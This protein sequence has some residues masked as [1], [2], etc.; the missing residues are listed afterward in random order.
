[1]SNEG[2]LMSYNFLR[3]AQSITN[4]YLCMHDTLDAYVSDFGTNGDVDGWDVYYNTY[5][6]GCWGGNLFGTA[7]DRDP[8]IGRTT[9][10]LS[11]EA[12]HFYYIKIMMKLTNNNTNKIVGGLTKGKIRWLTTTDTLWDSNKEIE[13]DITADDQW[14]LYTINV[15]PSSRWVG[16][17]NNLRIYPFTD[18]WS[19]DQFTIR[20]IKISSL[21]TFHCTNSSCSYYAEYEHECPGAG[22][23]GSCEAGT[24]REYYTLSSGINDQLIINIDGYGDE[25]FN[26]GSYE[27]IDGKE[28]AKVLGN[29][30]S[31]LNIGGYAYVTVEHTFFNRLKITS[32]T[33]GDESSVIVRSCTA[34]EELGFYSS[35]VDISSRSSGEDPATGF[36]Y[37]SSRLLTAYEINKL[38]DGDT[39]SFAYI[40]NPD[41]KSVEGGRNDY[42]QVGIGEGELDFHGNKTYVIIPNRGKT[43]ID[44]SHPFNNNGKITA[45][46]VYGKLYPNASIKIC[47]PHADGSFTVVH[48]LDVPQ[49]NPSKMYTKLHVNFRID[50]DI[51][52][53]KGDYIGVYD[54][55]LYVGKNLGDVP[56]ATYS[57]YNGEASGNFNVSEQYS[58]GVAGLA[59]YGRGDRAQT[60]TILDIDLGDRT[61][62]EEI[63]VYGREEKAY[64]DFNVMACL[65]MDWDVDT[66][67]ETHK[68][69]GFNALTG[70]GFTETHD[71]IAIGEE[72]LS[73]MIITPDNGHAGDSL[74]SESGIHSYFY[75]TGDA[76]WLNNFDCDGKHEFCWPRTASDTVS[77]NYDPVAFTAYFPYDYETKI[78]RSIIYFKEKNNFR[79]FTLSYYMGPYSDDGNADLK[80]FMRI[81]SYNSV[82]LD[83][84][85][86]SSDTSTV[87]PYLYS[88]PT[89]AR[90]TQINKDAY[91][92]SLF[93]D[94]TILEHEFDEIE[95]K[96]FRIYCNE[97]YSTKITEIELYSKLATDPSLSDNL[98]I[99]FSDYGNVWRSVS[100]SS[101]GNNKVSAFVGGSPRYFKIEIDSATQFEINELEVNVGDQ[102]VM[103]NCDDEVLL[104]EAKG[105]GAS[106]STSITFE[107]VYDKP[108]DLS[109]DIPRDL[110]A[111][112][113]GLLFSSPL[114]SESSIE[115]PEIGPKAILYEREDYPITNY[116]G[117]CAIN[118]ECYGLK[119]L[120]DDKDAYYTSRGVW[121]SFGTL[122]SGISLNYCNTD[123]RI[124]NK[125]IIDID[126]V[127]SSLYWKIA[128]DITPLFQSIAID[129]VKVYKGGSSLDIDRVYLEESDDTSSQTG[130]ITSDGMELNIDND[131]SVFGF[132]LADGDDT[133]DR[134]IIYH[135]DPEGL[136][137]A[138]LGDISGSSFVDSGPSGYN[139]SIYGNPTAYDSTEVEGKLVYFDGNDDITLMS[140]SEASTFESRFSVSFFFKSTTNGGD[141]GARVLTRDRSDYFAIL[142]NQ[143][144]G[145]PQTLEFADNAGYHYFNVVQ[146]DTLHHVVM[147]FDVSNN[148]SRCYFDGSLLYEDLSWGGFDS[149]S[150]P[151]VIASNTED[152]SSHSS[153]FIG[154]IG[155]IRFYNYLLSPTEINKLVYSS[156]FY[157]ANIR[158]SPDNGNNYVLA[159]TSDFSASINEN[160]YE[161]F[162]VDLGK[163]H[164]LDIIRNYG[165][166]SNKLF[167]STSSNVDFSNTDVSNPNSVDWNNST[168]D[169]V[170]WV[171][172]GL[173]CG[174]DTT[175]CL[176]KIGIY[177]DI[178]TVFCNG[179][180]YNCEWHSLGTILTSYPV[181]KNV[182]YGANVSG[183]SGYFSNFYPSKAVD[184]VYNELS[185]DYSWGFQDSEDVPYLDLVFDDRYTVNKLVLYHGIA[186]EDDRYR[187]ND[188]KFYVAYSDYWPGASVYLNNP[189]YEAGTFNQR[190]IF[191]GSTTYISITDIDDFNFNWDDFTIDFRVKFNFTGSAEYIVD[192]ASDGSSASSFSI[193][194]DSSDK[195][196]FYCRGYGGNTAVVNITSNATISGGHEY[197]MAFVRAGDYFYLYIDADYDNSST[198][199]SVLET[200]D[201]TVYLGMKN[202][203]TYF[204]NGTLD[205]FRIYDGAV[206]SG[207]GSF[208]IPSSEYNFSNDTLFLMHFE[209][210][211]YEKIVDVS[212]NTELET[213]DYFP[214]VEAY[215][216]RLR[217]T[218]HKTTSMY[219]EDVDTGDF[220]YFEGCFLRELELYT[221][222][223]ENYIDSEAWPVVSIDLNDQFEIKNHEL[224]NKDVTDIDTDWD[225]SEDYF[226]YSD[227][228][229]SD[230]KKVSF[231]KDGSEVNVY[232]SSDSSGDMEGAIEYVFTENVY[233]DAGVYMVTCQLYDVDSKDEIS[234]RIEGNEVIDVYPDTTGTSTWIDVS[235][236]V[237]ISNSGY[238][239]IKGYQHVDS[240]YHWGVRYPRIYRSSGLIKWVSVKRDTATG[241]SWDDDSDKY[242][243]D[244]LSI[245]K[246]YG[247][248]RYKPTQYSWWWNSNVSTL[249]EDYLVVKEEPRSLKI[250]YPTSSGVEE[251]SLIEGDNFGTDSFWSVKDFL[252][253]WMYIDD[254]DKLD[255]SF[256]DITFGSINSNP[257]IYYSWYISDLNLVSGWNHVKLKFEDYGITEPVVEDYYMK[258]YMDS[259]LKFSDPYMP[260]SSF[261]L[262][263]RGKGDPF[264]IYLT[265]LKIERNTFDDEVKFGNG[266][267]LVGYDYL[268]IP[269]NGLTLEKGSIEFWFKPYYDS[270]GID[271]FGDWNS[272]TLFTVTNNNNNIVGLAIRSGSWFEIIS[273]HVRQNLNS[274]VEN[275]AGI[276]LQNYIDINEVLHIALV[277]SNDG[278]DMDNDDT[279]RFYIN[280]DLYYT[281]KETWDVGDTKSAFIKLGG[282]NTRLASGHE[283]YGGGVFSNLKIYDYCK[284]NFETYTNDLS[285]LRSYTANEFIEISSDNINFYGQ[286]SGNL[287]IVFEK[288]PVGASRTI[289]VRANKNDRFK[290]SNQTANLIVDWLT[291]V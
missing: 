276:R 230:P 282:G 53:N 189:S 163:R 259:K 175:R 210:E 30:L 161:Y 206:W 251:I 148:I 258:A 198:Y 99:S 272:R 83:G 114:S 232:Y 233:I 105:N 158:T 15:G 252:G 212:G 119:N 197:H 289:Y 216:A 55:D 97:H 208:T 217:I 67:G 78:F 172:V 69:I 71:N 281:S 205:E 6:Y 231:F 238:Y 101:A 116:N 115:T 121:Y 201:N 261:R 235:D 62:I 120:V 174:D 149:S 284:K 204:F 286:G 56:D 63:A 14:H 138:Y 188:Y 124:L 229:F 239:T 98:T 109:V 5:M 137:A 263:Y 35:G 265:S 139:G 7:F 151:I 87:G 269:V 195:M 179:G 214:A 39:E 72:C 103:D 70:L 18:G 180:G 266:L 236:I 73:D 267:C 111:S 280:S 28:M 256:G 44:I 287:P 11:V 117:Q 193:Y 59:I 152:D 129:S 40:H 16:Y 77:Y 244:Y 169:D 21:D 182:A 12:E 23:R 246:V 160:Y 34:A 106:A 80:T 36:D 127:H 133:I 271:I 3:D 100:L 48:S 183:T 146:Q 84:I 61:N 4:S 74:E 237:S 112:S 196:R 25:I 20:F 75:V 211:G 225:N 82:R 107:N 2:S 162:A 194:K 170:R 277:W 168:K 130:A 221:Y 164:D 128:L 29:K 285:K 32:G 85:P 254:V 95:C 52:V 66:F 50:C 22:S 241:Y 260:L 171:R 131:S 79:S 86:Y 108:F 184:G 202:D 93:A 10:F 24:A 242:G 250:S 89:S 153:T 245:V 159:G 132:R 76:E 249:S 43:T 243:K 60:N 42:Y 126:T 226:R 13:F 154:Y 113:T 88:N 199:V 134:V 290:N 278:K 247:D 90:P 253:F 142:V 291:T 27:N 165:S 262:R 186:P 279:I 51:L 155:A 81:P 157:E 215:R 135:S 283:T 222:V 187:F 140:H 234:L 143:T 54:M 37:A 57:T 190:M 224:I 38:V 167:L 64:I 248:E 219:Y 150:R 166:M 156:S 118:C 96:G 255:T 270:Y 49:E 46:Y 144:S 136:A 227:S 274:F 17:I 41:Q 191:D 218:D 288:V 9:P 220:T 45:I 145:W 102:F 47:R 123:E 209:G 185:N 8:Y 1:M 92:A 19:G 192:R 264:N 223:S 200:N 213:V 122:T 178:E 176:D 104:Q 268:E 31:S 94:W 275:D 177:P 240:T 68:H 273:G 173:L 110:V 207:T 147:M 228:I 181:S 257:Q 26:L 58:Y 141:G 125:T 203:G 91:L 33:V 65:D